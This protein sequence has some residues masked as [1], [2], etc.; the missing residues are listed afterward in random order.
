[1]EKGN[2][3]ESFPFFYYESLVGSNQDLRIGFLFS[4]IG[5]YD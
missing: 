2:G 5:I 4:R 3:D 1:M